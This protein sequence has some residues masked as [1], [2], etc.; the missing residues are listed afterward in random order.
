MSHFR[1]TPKA[2]VLALVSSFVFA[3]P[4]MAAQQ[5]TTGSFQLPAYEK[6]KLDNGLTVFLLPQ[7]EVPLITVQATV[8]AGAVNDKV[9][10]LAQLTSQ[11]LLLGAGG[12]SKAQIEQLVDFLGASLN[13]DGSMEGSSLRADFMAKDTEQM[14]AVFHQVLTQPAFD[15]TEFDKLKARQVAAVAQAKESPRMVMDQYFNKLVFGAHPYG[16]AVSGT[17][18]SLQSISQQQVK[19]FHQSYYQPNNTAI[20][21]VGDFK[22][23]VMKAQLQKLFASWKNGAA[24]QQ[25]DLT[26]ALPKAEKAKVLLVNKADAIETTFSI[27]GIAIKQD[28]PDYVGISVVNTVLGGRFTSWLNDEL[29]VNSGLTYGARSGFER[30]SASGTFNIGSFTKTES[31]QAAVDLA[32]KTYQRLWDKGIDQATL[33]SAKA[34]VK[35]QF[36]PRFETNTALAGLLG[37]MYLYGFNQDYI[38][39]FQSKVDQLSVAESKRLI[40]SYFPK[41]QLQF[42]LIGKA[43][44]IKDVAKTY[45]EVKQVEITADSF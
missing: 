8:R 42:V 16:N 37:D 43:E 34:Y 40:N 26:A 7:H 18:A 31:T 1:K 36:P 19:N 41:D 33:D 28:N 13:S 20:S 39:S 6:L 4:V 45:G 15:A 32:L 35:G 25:P 44:A 22:A 2:V 9:A 5:N 24:V 17:A 23:E 21:I 3:M 12:K 14:L 27:G 30:Y 10:G 11:A 29:R 38:N